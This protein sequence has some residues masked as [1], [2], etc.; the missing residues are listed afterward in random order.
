[1]KP[2]E[3]TSICNI[4]WISYDSNALNQDNDNENDDY[5]EAGS[6]EDEAACSG[7]DK[8][9]V[10]DNCKAESPYHPFHATLRFMR[11]SHSMGNV[12]F[13]IRI[14]TIFNQRIIMTYME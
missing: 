8:D 12:S 9:V 2:A 7:V 10:G 6:D 13:F 11:I 3:L 4:L 1:M 14:T 5:D